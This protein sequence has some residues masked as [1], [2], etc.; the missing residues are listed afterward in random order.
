MRCLGF[1]N[2]PVI[3]RHEKTDNPQSCQAQTMINQ[4]R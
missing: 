3:G 4:S 1:G 2:L